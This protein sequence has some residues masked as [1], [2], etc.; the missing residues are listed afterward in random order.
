MSWIDYAMAMLPAACLTLALVHGLVWLRRRDQVWH[1]AFVSSAVAV[2]ALTA[3]EHQLAMAHTPDEYAATARLLQVPLALLFASL[4]A[5]V[6]LGLGVGNGWLGALAISLRLAAL[7]AG[8]TTGDHLYMRT[9]ESLE[10]VHVFGGDFPVPVGPANPWAALGMLANV[11]LLAFCADAWRTS[12]HQPNARKR[13]G[14]SLVVG[15]IVAGLPLAIFAVSV[16]RLGW[17]NTPLAYSLAFLPVILAMSYELSMSLLASEH[18]ESALRTSETRL[19]ETL[20]RS[21]LAVAALGLALFSWEPRR[22]T[23]WLSDRARTMFE[24]PP[25]GPVA[26]GDVLASVHAHDRDALRQVLA[27][28]VATR[29]AWDREFRVGAVD[30]PTRWISAHGSVSSGVDDGSLIVHCVAADVTAHHTGTDELR[31]LER[32]A[33]QQRDELAHLSRV[34]I[35]SELSGSLAHELNQ[36]LAAI[37]G[38]AQAALRYLERDPVDLEQIRAIVVDIV[39]A[40]RRAGEVIKRLRSMLRKE[41]ANYVEL[42]LNDV[43]VDALRLIRS[44]LL[45]RRVSVRWLPAGGMPNIAGDRVQL[46]QV[47]LNLVAN[48]CDAMA[49]ETGGREVTISTVRIAGNQVEVR[50]S[51]HGKGVADPDLE[52]IFQPFVT[53]KADGIGLGLSVCRSIIGAHHGRI[54]ATRNADRGITI[55]CELPAIDSTATAL[56]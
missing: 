50:V 52:Q 7:V 16:S 38:N 25:E 9:I 39:E 46:Q 8:F 55:H 6:R 48:A 53:S 37:L 27:A 1:L 22:S 20:E 10:T 40:D 13:L 35:L 49:D 14:A 43:V 33:A 5:F 4:V 21:E 36:P 17:F 47:L 44:D 24:L 26:L 23:L 34:T 54:W 56:A 12:R 19:A 32:E 3:L 18:L 28:A 51:D 11:A 41:G 30:G 45:N 29:S 42:E 2:A 31:R 15:S